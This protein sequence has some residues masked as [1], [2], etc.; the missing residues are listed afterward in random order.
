MSTTITLSSVLKKLPPEALAAL[1]A[2]ERKLIQKETLK[3]EDLVK[4]DLTLQEANLLI[5]RVASLLC[6]VD[7]QEDYTWPDN[8]E[9][10]SMFADK[11][12]ISLLKKVIK[13][14]CYK[15]HTRTKSKA[16]EASE[17]KVKIE[18]NPLIS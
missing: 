5:L 7:V 10:L 14:P 16:A 2:D 13:L 11:Q 8:L 6:A 1:T 4:E 12:L 3:P 9:G 17:P 15:A 18:E